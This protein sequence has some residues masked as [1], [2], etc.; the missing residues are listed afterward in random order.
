MMAAIFVLIISQGTPYS[1]LVEKLRFGVFILFFGSLSFS[2]IEAC[3]S[4]QFPYFKTDTY[5]TQ[6]IVY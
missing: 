1:K 2:R 4:Y 5:T 3:H 6:S